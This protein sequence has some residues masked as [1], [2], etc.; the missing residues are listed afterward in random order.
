MDYSTSNEEP[1]PEE[2]AEEPEEARDWNW[3]NIGNW[4]PAAKILITAVLAGLLIWLVLQILLQQQG[5]TP[6]TETEVALAN[7]TTASLRKIE[8]ELDR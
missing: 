3:P 8:E 7:D 4:S 6:N 5:R 2:E 1:E